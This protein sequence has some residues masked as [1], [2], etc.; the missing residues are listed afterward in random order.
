MQGLMMQLPLLISGLIA[1]ADRNHGDTTIVSRLAEDPHGPLHRTT[2]RE[3]HRRA[4]QL[5]NALA[6]LGRKRRQTPLAGIRITS[7]FFII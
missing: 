7:P 1:H 6:H 3:T 4:R 2:W 5:A